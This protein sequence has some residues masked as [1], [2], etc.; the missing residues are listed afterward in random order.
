VKLP[1]AV[2]VPNSAPVDDCIDIPDGKP[3]ADHVYG[4]VPPVAVTAC[5]AAYPTPTVAVDGLSAVVVMVRVAVAAATLNE[6]LFDA[7]CCGV[8]AS[9]TVTVIVKLPAAVG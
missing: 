2:G 8:L 6:K 7:V 4:V 9:W 3:L 1:A 5:A